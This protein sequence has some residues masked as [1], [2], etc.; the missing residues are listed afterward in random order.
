MSVRSSSRPDIVDSLVTS[1]TVDDNQ[2]PG[3]SLGGA[4][5][6]DR[7]REGLNPTSNNSPRTGGASK[8]AVPKWF[9]GTGENIE[10]FSFICYMLT[11]RPLFAGT[12]PCKP[13]FAKYCAAPFKSGK[14][15]DTY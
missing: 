10:S 13:F 8:G 9:K 14:T 5:A 11:Q 3:T 7:S 12:T 15:T 1:S 4:G 2:E 6:T